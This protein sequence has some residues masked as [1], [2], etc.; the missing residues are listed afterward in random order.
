MQT[1]NKNKNEEWGYLYGYQLREAEIGVNLEKLWKDSLG[2]GKVREQNFIE[3]F[4]K[5]YLHEELHRQIFY[6]ILELYEP[7]EELIVD[8]MSKSNRLK[9]KG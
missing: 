6:S 1:Q 3:N 2:R 7:K 8:K 5:I 9:V 4:S